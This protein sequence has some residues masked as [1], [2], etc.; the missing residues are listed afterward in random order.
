[1]TAII[2]PGC[3]SQRSP[4][5]AVGWEFYRGTWMCPSC[6]GGLARDFEEM[7]EANDAQ[8]RVELVDKEVPYDYPDDPHVVEFIDR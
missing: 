1:M 5:L 3:Y 7:L 8:D 4:K 6:L 2:C